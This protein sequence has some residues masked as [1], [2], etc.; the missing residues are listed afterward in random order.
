[1]KF[2]A[3]HPE[4]NREFVLS[5]TLVGHSSFVG[6]LAW[7]PPSDRFVGGGIVS[8]GMDTLVLLWDLHKGEVAETMKGHTSQVTGLAVDSNGDIISSSMDW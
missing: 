3:R 4:R 5:K 7:I 8:G 2:W 6:P 1:V